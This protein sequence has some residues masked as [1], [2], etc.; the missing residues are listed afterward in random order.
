MDN[1][2]LN[3]GPNLI[4]IFVF[5][6]ILSG[7][8]LGELFPCRVQSLFSNSMFVKH[9]LGFLTLLFFVTLTIPEIKKQP[10]LIGN[11]SLIYLW[12]IVM[13]KC[14]Y[15]IWFL[16]FGIIGTIYLLRMYK[17]NLEKEGI[18][19]SEKKKVEIINTTNKYLTIVSLI[20]TVI[21]F[22][23]YMGAKKIEYKKKFNYFDFILGKPRC[24]HLTPHHN[25]GY[26]KLLLN[27][28][29]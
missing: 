12:F 5:V 27:A 14:Y 10:Y 26:F 22:L 21:G 20:S 29:S 9:A 6:L 24:R 19:E 15:T 13:S 23:I 18:T 11:T 16:I 3:I 25:M 4:S 17:E 7:N 1:F 2:L 8:Y 28:F